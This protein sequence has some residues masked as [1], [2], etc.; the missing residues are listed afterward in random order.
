MNKYVPLSFFVLFLFLPV[1][2]GEDSLTTITIEPRIG[3]NSLMVTQTYQISQEGLTTFEVLTISLSYADLHIFDETGDLDYEIGKNIII[4]RN[5]YRKITVFFREPTNP[6]FT[7]TVKYWVPTT[8][9]G[10]PITGKYI[11]KIV[12]VTDSTIVKFVIPLTGITETSR[13]TPKAEIEEREDSTVFTYRFSED[14]VIILNYEL[15]EGIDYTDTETET[16]LY[17]DYTFEV[18]YPRKTEIFLEDIKFFI[19]YGFPVFLKETGT[20]LRFTTL[21]ITLDKEEHTW[22]AAEYRGEGDIRILINNTASYPSQFLAHEFIH[23][24]VGVFPRYLEEGIADYF[25]GQVNR[26]FA[27]PRPGN[28]IPNTEP[29]FQTYERQFGEL[30]DITESRYGLGLTDHQEALIYAKYSKGTFLIYEIAYSCGHETV[31]EMLAIL[32]E[33]R[34]CDINRLIFL[35]TEGDTVYKILNRYGFDVVPPYAY[36]AEELLEEVEERSWWSNVLCFVFQF[37]T[38]IRTADPGDISQIK[39][40]IEHTGEIA[41]QTGLIANGVVLVF[42]FFIGGV[43]LRKIYR[44]R[45]ENPRM[46]Y[47]GY[48]IPVGVALSLFSYFFYEFLFSG[49]KFRWILGNILA[50][51]GLGFTSGVGILLLLMHY[52]P[53]EGKA[54]FTVDVVW[55]AWFCAV[56]VVGTGFFAIGGIALVLGYVMS[57][58][59]LLII[60]R[61]EYSDE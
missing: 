22:A 30:V 57:L 1:T 46:L 44:I 61:R 16:F 56:F 39:A 42:L 6:P 35:L 33:E 18:T 54:K 38:K 51:S 13:S 45:R 47:F 55:S 11:Y 41:S 23:S 49:Y 60:R 59:V 10:K 53:K 27:P 5:I 25:E 19:D 3:E 4:G 8:V 40:D 26:I 7:F 12:N 48:A 28:Y 14:T 24:Y 17:Q 9:T 15:K 58:L 29:F 21:T 2:A 52:C 36:P 50:P 37:E 20:P 31:Q 43:A 34:N 32:K